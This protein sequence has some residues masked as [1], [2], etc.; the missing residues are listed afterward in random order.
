M[1]WVEAGVALVRKNGKW[2]ETKM[3]VYAS[4]YTTTDFMCDCGHWSKEH[5]NNY[6][7]SQGNSRGSCTHVSN[8]HGVFVC[9]CKRFHQESGEAD[10]YDA[11]VRE[12][13]EDYFS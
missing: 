11:A 3:M 9:P 5:Y 7:T 6:V 2:E 10:N 4:T 13:G 8:S 1:S 12:L